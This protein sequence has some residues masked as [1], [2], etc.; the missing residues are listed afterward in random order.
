MFKK[1][2]ALILV[3]GLS[4]CLLLITGLIIQQHWLQKLFSTNKNT[5][6]SVDELATSSLP[7]PTLSP[8]PTPEPIKLVF[9]GD[10][11]FDRHIR[12]HAQTKGYD[13]ILEDFKELFAMADLV[14][15]NLEGPISNFPSRSIGSIVGSTDNYFFT[16]E[17]AIINMLQNYGNFALNLGNNHIYNF[18]KEGLK[19]TLTQLDA[20]HSL[21]KPLY[22]FGYLGSQAPAEYQSYVLVDFNLSN[23]NNYN[24]ALVNYNQ[25]IAG[26][27][28]AVLT[29]I[30]TVREK[31]DYIIVYP[32]WGIEYQTVANK[33]IQQ[34]AWQMLDAGA[35]MIVGGHPH[36]IQQSEIYHNKHIYYSLGNFVFDQY[37]EPNVKQGLLLFV[38]LD[39]HNK[40]LSIKEYQTMLDVSGKTKLISPVD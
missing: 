23:G 22:Y 6:S 2:Q 32:H 40:Q 7:T 9:V 3:F 24:I 19:Q 37:F 1:R 14:I 16:F 38:E 35:D 26:G 29:D 21:A 4:I 36:V 25:F 11:M 39:T 30:A 33:N 5:N 15:A 13:Y 31:S 27:L 34:L 10:M 18:G 17:P 28:E 8:T 12:Q 20:N